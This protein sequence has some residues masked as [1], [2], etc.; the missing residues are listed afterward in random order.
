MMDR[1]EVAVVLAQIAAGL[2]EIH[3]KIHTPEDAVWH[4]AN[5]IDE[6]ALRLIGE[7]V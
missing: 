5:V 4:T 1:N 2:R 7:D 6:I 3:A